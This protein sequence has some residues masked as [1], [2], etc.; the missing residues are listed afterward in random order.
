GLAVGDR[1][2]PARLRAGVVAREERRR[3][4]RA[5]EE[6]AR[7]AGA[8]ELLGR[9]RHVEQLLAGA[10]VLDRDLEPGDA[11]L[12]EPVPERGIVAARALHDPPHARRRAFRLEPAA[13]RVLQQ[14]LLVR[15]PE[16]HYTASHTWRLITSLLSDRRVARQT[17]AALGDDVALDVRG[18]A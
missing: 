5:G 6:R 18:A 2:Q 17:E 7:R 3:R 1:R 10:A 14:D 16:V 11:Q 15:E 4:E 9:E 8:A 12:R 13:D